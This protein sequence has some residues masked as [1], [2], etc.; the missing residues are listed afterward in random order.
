[1]RTFISAAGR[2]DRV[3]LG[4]VARD[5][6][7]A[8]AFARARPDLAA[9]RAEVH[10]DRVARIGAHSL[11][12]HGEPAL[13]RREALVLAAPLPAAVAR[14]VRC[15]LALAAHARANRAALHRAPA[16]RG[17]NARG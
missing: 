14:E 13:L 2:L 15:G 7:P 17:G 1:M 3:D 11:A 9:R 4:Q 6:C 5:R 8:L 10:A 16:Q 12:F